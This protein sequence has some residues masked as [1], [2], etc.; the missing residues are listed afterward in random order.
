MGAQINRITNANVYLDNGSL[1]GQ[2]E[3]AD[4]PSLN[5]LM[6]EHKA[7]G[8]YGKREFVAGIDKMEMRLKFNAFYGNLMAITADPFTVHNLQIRSN[9]EVYTG[10]QRTS[11]Q[12]V[13]IFVRGQFKKTPG[14][15]FK[16]QDN[17]E[18]ETMLAVNRMKIEHNG[19]SILE[20][21]ADANIYTV[22][23]VDLLAAYRANLGI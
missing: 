1:L 3:E 20:F 9:L 23:G 12:P 10:G 22:N 18:Y 15:N 21:D 11:Q 6:V 2:V 14:G 7:L 5:M 13:K 17:V 19:V 8:M 16:A 4:A